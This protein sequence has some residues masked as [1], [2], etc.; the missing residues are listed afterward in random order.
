MTSPAAT[1]VAAAVPDEEKPEKV[2]KE[3]VRANLP[4]PD[5]GVVSGR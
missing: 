1:T 2:E 3:P 5:L 4:F